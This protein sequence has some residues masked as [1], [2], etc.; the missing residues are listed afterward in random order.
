M[1]D[2]KN[3]AE[4]YQEINAI[5]QACVEEFNECDGGREFDEFLHEAIDSHS[6]IIYTYMNHQVLQHSA[7]ESYAADN[8]GAEVMILNGQINWAALAYGAMYGDCLESAA[9]EELQNA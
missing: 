2:I 5:V 9:F 3:C 6:W 8:Y 1:D 4:Y 7:N